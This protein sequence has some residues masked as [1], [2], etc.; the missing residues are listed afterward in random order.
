MGVLIEL[1]AAQGPDECALA[2]GHA[3]RRLAEDAAA[4]DVQVQ[5]LETVRAP[6]GDGWRSILLFAEGAQAEAL[7]QAWT[8]TLQWICASPL[9][10]L[11]RR[12]NWFFGGAAYALPAAVPEAA[13]R[14]DTL[15]ASG[16]GGQHVNKTASAVRVT[17]QATG[18]S[19]VMQSERSQHA[20]RRLALLLLAHR[21]E[22]L[23]AQ[24]DQAL[25]ARRRLFHHQLERGGARRVFEGPSFRERAMG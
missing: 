21:R 5:T 14:I 22:E 18:L 1:S 17:D 16:P 9:R 8:G 13:L 4:L 10:P 2:V 15:R 3:L 23:Q 6:A 20:N 19:V 25:R 24:A 11:H 12:R 7:A